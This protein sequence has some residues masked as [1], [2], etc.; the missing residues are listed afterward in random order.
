MFR[1]IWQIDI[2]DTEGSSCSATLS[3]I[4]VELMVA[5]GNACTPATWFVLIVWWRLIKFAISTINTRLEGLCTMP[6]DSPTYFSRYN[7]VFDSITHRPSI[8]VLIRMEVWVP[9]GNLNLFTDTMLGE[10]VLFADTINFSPYNSSFGDLP[11]LRIIGATSPFPS[12]PCC[13]RNKMWSTYF[14]IYS[15]FEK[16]RLF[17]SAHI[18]CVRGVEMKFLLPYCKRDT[19]NT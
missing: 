8:F 19:R 6:F 1:S 4:S 5:I 16:N 3:T 2:V 17:W 13:R 12:K 11:G 18:F 15:V 14:S 10:I 7:P 9:G